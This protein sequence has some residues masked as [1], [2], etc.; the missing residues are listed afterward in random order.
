MEASA[1]KQDRSPIC[2]VTWTLLALNVVVYLWDRQGGLFGPGIVFADLAVKPVEVMRALRGSDSNN[3]LVAVATL[4][5]SQFLHGNSIHLVSNLI[6]LV[7]FG[8]AVEQAF[9]PVRFAIYYLA[10]GVAAAAAH[11]Y[12]DPGSTTPMLG[13]SGAIGGVLGAY[14]LLFPANRIELVVP[15]LPFI[16]ATFSAWVL[17]GIWFLFQVFVPQSG[18][19]NWAHVGGFLAGM[20]TVLVAGGR[21]LVL[22]GRDPDRDFI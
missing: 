5:T 13:A 10:W 21:E 12:I 20:L 6:F 11:I 1:E 4:L 19:A 18:V 9:G 8:R 22:Q 3:D 7:V 15:L 16:T 14:L 17:L 2:A